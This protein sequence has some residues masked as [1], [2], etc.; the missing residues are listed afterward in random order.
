M[1]KQNELKYISQLGLNNMKRIFSGYM[2]SCPVCKEGS[3]PWKT[4]L[5]ILTEKKSFIT[6]YCHNCGLDTNLKT[7]IQ[8][9]NPY[10]YSDYLNEERAEQV[11]NLKNGTLV[12]KQSYKSD[13]SNE[14]NLQY[15]FELNNKYFKSAKQFKQAVDF[16][17]KRHIEEHIDTLY[18]NVHPNHTLS[19]MLIFPF[20]MADSEMIY[21]FQGR[22]TEHKRFH[23]HS[24]NES[25]KVYNIY[26]VNI[27]E[28]VYVFESIID[29]MMM[30]N[31]IAMLGTTLSK[32]ITDKMKKPIYVCDNDFTGMKKCLQYLEE[33]KKCFIFPDNFRYKDFN[34]A[35]MDGINKSTLPKLILENVYQG[36]NGI[37]KIKL[38]LT[39]RKR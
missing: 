9:V 38:N 3:S 19:G 5:Y 35:V 14:I 30:D 10:I 31:S 2:C 26:N 33:G 4:R 21:G 18:Y 6:V 22:H 32:A 36:L 23:T 17:K 37:S 20:I 13:F 25:L 29:S 39:K 34:E 1:E 11:Q 24:K 8:K 28:P 7:F 12:K 16:C 27:D 15:V